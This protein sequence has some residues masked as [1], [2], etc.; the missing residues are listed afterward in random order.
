M[1]NL[2]NSP[3]L[4]KDLVNSPQLR[5]YLVNQG[6]DLL[7]LFLKLNLFIACSFVCD[8]FKKAFL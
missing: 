4:V 1:K 8:L 2:V 7:P 5:N 3:L 6:L